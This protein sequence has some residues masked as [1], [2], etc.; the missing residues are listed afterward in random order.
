[1]ETM[2]IIG[3]SPEQKA[4]PDHHLIRTIAK[5]RAWFEDL[6]SG[7][8]ASINHIAAR[9]QLPASEVSRQLALA[10][11][12]PGIV[13]AILAGRQ[14]VDLTVKAL[15]RLSDLPLDWGAQSRRLGFQNRRSFE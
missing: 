7:A 15:M 5:A 4:S 9:D 11:L 12:A 8:I 13:T 1:M 10:F 2:L 3:G 6:K 14:P